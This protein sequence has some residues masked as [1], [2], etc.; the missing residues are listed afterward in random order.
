MARP[1][2]SSTSFAARAATSVWTYV[3]R[4]LS[5][6]LALSFGAGWANVVVGNPPW[7][8]FRHMS[9]DL[10]K[11]FRDLAK[12]ERVYVGGKFAT[13]NDLARC[14]RC[15]PP[16]SICARPDA[17][18]SCAARR[19]DAR[20]VRESPRRLVLRA[21]DRLG[22]SLDHGRQ[23]AA[24]FLVPSCVASGAGAPCPKPCRTRSRAYSGHLPSAMRR[25]RWPMNALTVTKTRP[26]RPKACSRGG[27]AYRRSFRQGA[28]LVPRM[29]CLVERKSAGRLGE[30]PPRPMSPAAGI[31]QERNHGK[32][33]PGVEH[34]VEAEFLHPVLL[35]E[36]ILP[37]RVFH[38]VRRRGAGD[39]EGRSAGRR[40]RR[41]TA[42]SL[43]CTAGCRGGGDME[44]ERR[45]RH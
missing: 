13:Q 26:S 16:P 29:L 21:R 12:G 7:V 23:R 5:R 35:G 22:R 28:T 44:R 41:P 36:S 11:R 3:A 24:A 17:S 33:L 39:S 10:Q 15:A 30:I 20:A 18:L 38:P 6:P 42:A 40:R 14:S 37:Y 2:P 27:S 43:A 34:R 4:N 31:S 25:K 32:S 8:A 19:A 9:A 45:E 1:T